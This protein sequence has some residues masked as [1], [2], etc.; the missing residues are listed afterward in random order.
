MADLNELRQKIDVLDAQILKAF[1]ERQ[2]V[3]EQIA[4]Y[5][6]ENHL[7]I[8]DAQR[9]EEKLKKIENSV[10]EEN[11]AHARLL[12]LLLMELSKDRQRKSLQL[13]KVSLEKAEPALRK[14][15]EVFESETK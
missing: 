11:S 5:K 4:A 10:S 7:P 2:Q 9:E 1:E 14:A 15:L 3:A 6:Q 12:Y 13:P 8:T